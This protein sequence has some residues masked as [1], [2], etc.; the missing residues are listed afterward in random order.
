MISVRDTKVSCQQF[1]AAKRLRQRGCALEERVIDF[2]GVLDLVSFMEQTFA[3]TMSDE[4]LLPENFET[5]QNLSNFVEQKPMAPVS[6]VKHR[7]V[8]Q[9][10]RFAR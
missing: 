3:I 4:E 8:I 5:I 7:R 9:E 2:L 6:G 10:F 1:P